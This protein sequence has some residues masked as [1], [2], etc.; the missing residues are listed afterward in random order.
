[1]FSPIYLF[2]PVICTRIPT[3]DFALPSTNQSRLPSINRVIEYANLA[4]LAL[5]DLDKDDYIPPPFKQASPGEVHQLNVKA[6]AERKLKEKTRG[7]KL[8]AEGFEMEHGG[9]IVF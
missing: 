9:E 7:K 6:T 4:S 1:M 8:G 2:R 3:W 5:K